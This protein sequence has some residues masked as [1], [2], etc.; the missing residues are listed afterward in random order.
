MIRF[1]ILAL[2][3]GFASL[4]FAYVVITN[5]LRTSAHHSVAKIDQ[6]IEDILKIIDD[7][8]SD[9]NCPDWVKKEYADIAHENER[10]RAVG[11]V[12]DAGEQWHVCSMFG[13][14]LSKMNYWSGAK[15][16]DVFVGRSLLT[17]HFP[18][19]SFVVG[20]EY[21]N[22][23]AFAYINPRRVLG[24]WIEP[25]LPYANYSLSLDGENVPAYTRN[26][27]E[28][29]SMLLQSVHSQNYPYS[30]QSAASISD[31]LKRSGVYWLRILLVVFFI[32]SSYQLLRRTLLDPV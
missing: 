4:V 19:T 21:G 24:Y 29:Q 17:V 16:E 13:R 7:L 32:W 23:K 2:L 15:I 20:K 8:P 5:E 11:Y 26:P 6:Q 18:E 12:F 25:S 9:K 27:L 1:C 14:T 28:L 3:S 30:I 31:V 10:I 22:L